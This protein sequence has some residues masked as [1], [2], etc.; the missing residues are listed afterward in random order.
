MRE[1]LRH[2]RDLWD[3]A[4][5]RDAMGYILTT[6]QTWQVDD[7]YAHGRAEIAACLTRLDDLGL[8]GTRHARALDFGCGIGRLTQALASHYTRVDGVDVSPTMIELAKANNRHRKRVHYSVSGEQL[9]YRAGTFDLIYTIIVLQHMPQRFAHAYIRD[10]IRMLHP[11][12]IAVFEIPDGPDVPH[13]D[14]CLSMYGTPRARVEEIVAEA[15]GEIVDVEN[16]N[17]CTWDC[18]RYTVKR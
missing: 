1:E 5:Q 15:G 14:G 11:D 4:A 7:F 6:G 17:P 2:V 10:F 18:N 9:K 8:R 3:I 13:S 16:V 12:G